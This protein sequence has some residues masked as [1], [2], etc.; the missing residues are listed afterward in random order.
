M[1]EELP[2]LLPADPSS[3]NTYPSVS[4]QIAEKLRMARGFQRSGLTELAKLYE[5][6]IVALVSDYIY[7][8]PPNVSFLT[9]RADATADGSQGRVD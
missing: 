5:Q 4:Q 7:A 1:S 9:R 3:P 2:I 6:Q 8:P